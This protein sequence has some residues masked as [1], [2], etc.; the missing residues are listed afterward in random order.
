MGVITKVELINFMCHDNLTCVVRASRSR[1]AAAS[2]GVQH[3]SLG[4]LL[5]RPDF[6]CLAE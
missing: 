1:R 4:Q 5:I 3:L 6:L 2:L